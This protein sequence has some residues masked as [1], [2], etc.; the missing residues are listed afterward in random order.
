MLTFE[1]M[2]RAFIVGGIL[3]IIIPLIGSNVVFKRLSMIGDALSHVSLSGVTIGLLFG[4][5]PVLTAI[6]SCIIAAIVIEVMRHH[7]KQY[8]ELSIAI[9]MSFG[10]GLAGFLLKYVNNATNFDSFLFGSIVTISDFELNLIVLLGISVIVV[11]LMFYRDFFFVAFDEQSAH[12]AGIK[13]RLMNYIFAILIAITISVASRTV[14][15]LVVSSMM[16]IPTSC[17]VLISKSYRQTLF[18]AV[19]F[20]LIFI[21]TG[22][23]LSYYYDFK[24]GGTIVLLAVLTLGLIIIVKQLKKRLQKIH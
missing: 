19:I 2:R 14:G 6:V 17:A 18:N 7:F 4:F 1:F 11:V 23:T 12:L 5:N 22:I 24:P 13:V 9:V 10:I 20:A 16:V 3:A 15:A 21:W 8:S